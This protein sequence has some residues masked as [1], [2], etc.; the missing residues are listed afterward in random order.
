MSTNIGLCVCVCEK[1]NATL[2]IMIIELKSSLWYMMFLI[3]EMLKDLHLVYEKNMTFDEYNHANDEQTKTN[4]TQ[5]NE[6]VQI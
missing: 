2:W 1:I 5:K 3:A 6:I 4:A